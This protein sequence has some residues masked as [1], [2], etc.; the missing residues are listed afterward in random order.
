MNCDAPRDESP[1][2]IKIRG[3]RGMPRIQQFMGRIRDSF[4]NRG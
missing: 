3:V 4:I 1:R 2:D